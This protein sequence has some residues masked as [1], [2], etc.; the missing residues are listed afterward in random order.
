MADVVDIEPISEEKRQSMKETLA[1]LAE[2]RRGKQP[3]K[4]ERHTV[5]MTEEMP[6][7]QDQDDVVRKLQ[8]L[9]QRKKE[10]KVEEKQPCKGCNDPTFALISVGIVA[11]L[12]VLGGYKAYK[13]MYPA[14]SNE[15]LE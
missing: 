7:K 15:I 13:W 3:E 1:R 6:V 11:C 14:I 8:I 9:A 5:E 12:V 4:I 2:K 10:V